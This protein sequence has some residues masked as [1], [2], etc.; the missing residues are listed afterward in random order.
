M[1]GSAF[2]TAF[3]NALVR[4]LEDLE[5]AHVGAARR[6]HDEL[7]EHLALDVRRLEH[8][9]VRAAPDCPGIGAT[10]FSTWNSKYVWSC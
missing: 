7:R 9:G 10:C 5:G 2:F 8:V 1:R 6:I 3:V 4:R